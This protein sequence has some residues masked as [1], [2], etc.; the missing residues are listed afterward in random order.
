MSGKPKRL[1]CLALTTE[2]RES[3]GMGNGERESDSRAD[4]GGEGKA[5]GAN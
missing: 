1:Y 2:M 4:R 5:R 3:N